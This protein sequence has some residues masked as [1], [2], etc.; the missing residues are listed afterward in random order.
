MPLLK[1]L[2]KNHF[3]ELQVYNTLESLRKRTEL[4]RET[5]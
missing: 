3:P 4:W 2:K 1:L 5:Q